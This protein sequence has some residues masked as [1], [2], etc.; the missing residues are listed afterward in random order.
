MKEYSFEIQGKEY[1]VSINKV[2]GDMA[3]VVVNGTP[4]TVKLNNARKGTAP[5]D[6]EPEIPASPS[7]SSLGMSF[8]EVHGNAS[9]IE[10]IVKS[11]LPGTV[12]FIRVKV[13]DKVSVGQEVLVLEAMKMENSIEAEAYGTVTAIHVEKGDSVLEGQSLITIG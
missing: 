4:Y 8:Q 9:H 3:D 12:S 1:N 5:A 6:L 7:Q 13:G 11:P 10:S 2:E